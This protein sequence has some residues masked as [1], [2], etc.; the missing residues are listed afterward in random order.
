MYMHIHTCKY[1]PA[2]VAP[3]LP[4]SMH[5]LHFTNELMRQ[6]QLNGF[7]RD[8][9][10]VCSGSKFTVY[11][12]LQMVKQFSFGRGQFS[13]GNGITPHVLIGFS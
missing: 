7:V 1:Y 5:D 6:P 8:Y 3:V 2:R 13:V 9:Y 11:V 10:L 4:A 12:K